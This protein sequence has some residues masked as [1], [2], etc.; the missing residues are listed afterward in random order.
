[1]SATLTY[2]ILQAQ[3]FYQSDNCIGRVEV[4]YSEADEEIRSD[5]VKLAKYVLLRESGVDPVF[6]N[7][8]A[9]RRASGAMNTDRHFNAHSRQRMLSMGKNCDKL[10]R[11]AQRAGIQTQ[12]KFYCGQLGSYTDPGAWVSTIDDVIDTAKR[13]QLTIRGAVKYDGTPE[14]LEPK[15]KKVQ[16][17]PDIMQDFVRKYTQE[18]P[19]LKERVTKNPRALKELKEKIIAKHTRPKLVKPT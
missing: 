3:E 2:D 1:M 5:E 18:D 19:A 14:Y 6:A 7:M 12:G 10:G 16:M 15:P 8:R 4:F 9:C 13:K 17:A 11:L